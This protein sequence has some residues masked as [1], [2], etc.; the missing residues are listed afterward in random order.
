MTNTCITHWVTQTCIEKT[1]NKI[2]RGPS[3]E[4]GKARIGALDPGL[5]LQVLPDQI[6]ND[7][8][9]T[10]YDEKHSIRKYVTL[11]HVLATHH[12]LD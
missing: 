7:H 10:W 2:F 5:R 8:A 6:P 3:K 1:D 4:S 9:V 11:R 12:V